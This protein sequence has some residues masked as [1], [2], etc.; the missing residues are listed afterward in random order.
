MYGCRWPR[1]YHSCAA[2]LRSETLRLG[3][4][5]AEICCLSTRGSRLQPRRA[6]SRCDRPATSFLALSRSNFLFSKPPIRP[7]FLLRNLRHRSAGISG[8]WEFI[9]CNG[10]CGQGA[11]RRLRGTDG[12]NPPRS[13]RE[14]TNHRFLP[15]LTGSP[16]VS[17]CVCSS[18]PTT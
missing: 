1:S 15:D 16:T 7:E 3:F 2:P 6:R 14:S 4:E 18:L 9:G 5:D 17:C 13:S 10:S 8:T 11:D 12:S